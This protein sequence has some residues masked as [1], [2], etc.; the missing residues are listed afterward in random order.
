MNEKV[1]MVMNENMIPVVTKDLFERVTK[2]R[3]LS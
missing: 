3:I 2:V 1:A